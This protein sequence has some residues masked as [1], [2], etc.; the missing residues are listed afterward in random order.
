[1]RAN[2]RIVNLVLAHFRKPETNE[3]TIIDGAYVFCSPYPPSKQVRV[4]Q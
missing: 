2:D 4:D 1:M 3:Q